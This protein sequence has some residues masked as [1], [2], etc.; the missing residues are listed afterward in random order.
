M[1][2]L[3]QVYIFYI[4]TA[5]VF[6]H[7]WVFTVIQ[8]VYTG[9]KSHR[10]SS[11]KFCDRSRWDMCFQAVKDICRQFC[12]RSMRLTRFGGVVLCSVV[13][14]QGINKSLPRRIY[15][16]FSKSAQPEMNPFPLQHR[17]DRIDNA[18][19]IQQLPWDLIKISIEKIKSRN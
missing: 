9:C 18:Q 2:Y 3:C 19:L 15:G 7:L 4:I 12:R 13:Q 14:T 8:S 5:H 17:C 10:G 6:D 11:L 1:L 16:V